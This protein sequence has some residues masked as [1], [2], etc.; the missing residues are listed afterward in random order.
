[1][2][3]KPVTLEGAARAPAV[4]DDAPDFAAV[5]TDLSEKHLSDFRGKV[6]ILS[7][8]PSL[9][10]P[11]CDAETRAFNERA[12][13]LG[14]KFV[15]LTVS[16]DLPFAQKRWCAAAGIDRVITLS[17]SKL[18]QVGDRY[19]LRIREHG[20]LARAVTVIDPRGIIRYQQIVPEIATE[21]N[22]DAAI[23]AATG[24]ARAAAGM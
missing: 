13:A 16:M 8:V 3:G 2:K 17:D 4:G 11:V 23:S 1:M 24:A 18:R 20:L 14:D 10:T 22:Y 9:D 12:S 19:T 7:T 5:A 6:V 21:P 15:V